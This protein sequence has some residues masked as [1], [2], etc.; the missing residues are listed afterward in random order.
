MRDTNP[1]AGYR[2]TVLRD[3]LASAAAPADERMMFRTT[4]FRMPFAI[5]KSIT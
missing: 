5:S 4:V 1:P 2:S 3:H